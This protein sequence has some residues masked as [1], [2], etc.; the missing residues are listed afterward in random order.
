MREIV[1]LKSFD[2]T[3]KLYEDRKVY[4]ENIFSKVDVSYL[5]GIYLYD[6]YNMNNLEKSLE[7][8][9]NY[10]QVSIREAILNLPRH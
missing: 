4:V 3:K 8:L 6:E 5:V 1:K 7:D 9:G 10:H 2:N